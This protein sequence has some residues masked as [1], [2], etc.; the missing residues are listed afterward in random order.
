MTG[1]VKFF[2]QEKGY[3]FIIDKE[4]REEVFVHI[5]AIVDEEKTLASGQKVSYEVE[6]DARTNKTKACNVKC[7]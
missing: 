6:T 7:L 4:T 2:N 3:G 5:T 1:T